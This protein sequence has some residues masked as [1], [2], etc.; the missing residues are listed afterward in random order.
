MEGPALMEY[1]QLQSLEEF[2]KNVEAALLREDAR[3]P[4][5]YS[6]HNTT[7]WDKN[8]INAE[9]QILLKSVSCTANVYAIFTAPKGSDAFT[10]RYIGK[11]TRKLARQR[12]RN[13]LIA[14]N[15]NTYAKLLKVISNR[16]RKD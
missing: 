8:Q 13:H 6:P 9:N 4:V 15:E 12:V 16:L 3:K 1:E 2:L 11:T 7:Q 5:K 10:L 14:K